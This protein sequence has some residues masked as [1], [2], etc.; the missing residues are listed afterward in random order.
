M[1]GVGWGRAGGGGR[2][3]PPNLA[4]KGGGV[5][6]EGTHEERVRGVPV[7]RA[8]GGRGKGSGRRDSHLEVVLSCFCRDWARSEG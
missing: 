4:V 5:V 6:R 2:K 1:G 7:Q 8:R 3:S